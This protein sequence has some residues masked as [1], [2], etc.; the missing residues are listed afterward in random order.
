MIKVA[1]NAVEAVKSGPFLYLYTF[2]DNYA[3]SNCST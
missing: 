2:E 3:C 1:F